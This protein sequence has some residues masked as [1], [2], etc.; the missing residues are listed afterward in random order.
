MDYSI[1]TISKNELSIPIAWA[2]K[3][4]WNPGLYDAHAF[5]AADPKG[6]LM[7]FLGNEPIASISAVSYGKD[8]GFLGF[9]I[10]KPSYRGK[11]YGYR[12]WQEALKHLPT[13]NIALDGVVA[14][15]SNYKKSGFKLAYRNIRFEGKG[16]KN[17]PNDPHI[18]PLTLIPI[19]KLLAYDRE[20]FIFPRKGF[21]TRWVTQ[22]KNL[23]IGYIENNNLKGYGVIRPCHTGYKIGPLFADSPTIAQ[24]F[25]SSL[26]SF[27]GPT[28]PVFLDVPEVNPQ[29]VT[30]A[31]THKMKPMFETARMYTKEFPNAPLQKI[32]GVTTFELG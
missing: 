24:A 32:F 5:Y 2:A 22:P 21:L 7:G 14:Q 16:A 13:Q 17:S 15:Q 10:V 3:E 4:G 23:A 30:L 28:N 20:V 18:K 29:A 8:F 27:A 25:F 11:G 1:R 6:F 12:I 31:K 9:Y 26:C 19:N